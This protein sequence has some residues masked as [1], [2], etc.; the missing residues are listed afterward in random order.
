MSDLQNI[1]FMAPRINHVWPTK[2]IVHGSKNQP[3]LTY[4]IYCSWLQESTMSDIQNILFMAPKIKILWSKIC[5][6]NVDIS[7]HFNAWSR[8]VE[9]VRKVGIRSSKVSWMF[10]VMPDL[11]WGDVQPQVGLFILLHVAQVVHRVVNDHKVR[12]DGD[13]LGETQSGQLDVEQELQRRQTGNSKTD[14]QISE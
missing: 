8:L 2:Y 3:C 11:L 7:T 14:R 10:T 6:T 5:E 12:H 1:L 4:K 9:A 13:N